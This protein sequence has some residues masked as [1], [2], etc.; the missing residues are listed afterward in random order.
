MI[1]NVI[2]I[3]RA[4]WVLPEYNVLGVIMAIYAKPLSIVLRISYS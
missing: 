1:I 3:Q 2:V 4:T